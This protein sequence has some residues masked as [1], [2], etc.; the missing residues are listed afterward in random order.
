[1]K[2]IAK[3][4]SGLLSASLAF[5]F[6]APA[7]SEAM[8]AADD[9]IASMSEV[10]RAG[11]ENFDTSID[12]SKF[13]LD[14]YTEDL[15]RIPEV[16]NYVLKMPDLFY[17]DINL[18]EVSVGCQYAEDGSIIVGNVNITYN[19]T[20]EEVA[21]LIDELDAKVKEVVNEVVTD[22][23]TELQKA[24]SLHDYIVLNT[25]YDTSG[26]L[27]DLNNGASAYDI[28]IC[29]NGVCEGY[30]Q[31]YN[32]L[33]EECGVSSIMVTSYDMRH[34][35]NL[36]N[37][38]NEWYHVD[39]TWDD[40][41]PDSKGRVNHKYFMLSDEEIMKESD[42]RKPHYNWDSKGFE[43]TSK[44]YD[45]AF[46]SGV[47]TEIFLRGDKWYF[48]SNDG[49]YS[50]YTESADEV[51]T[52]V[53]LGE[54]KWPVWGDNNQAYW[55][56]RYSSMII[57]DNKVYFN[58]PEM[59]YVMNLD[60]S[61]KA[62]LQYVNPYDTNG[63]VYGMVL[64]DNILYAVIKQD[65]QDEGT[66][67]KAV[68]LAER[69][70]ELNE[71][72]Y[73]IPSLVDQ[74]KSLPDG[75]S[76]KFDMKD[77]DTENVLPAAAIESMKDKDIKITLNLEGYS[78]DIRSKNIK[79][80][81]ARD[82]N[83]EIKQDQK[84]I[85]DDM[86][87]SVS[88]H[89]KFVEL[90]LSHNGQF[91]LTANISYSIGSE[92]ANEPAI[93]YYYNQAESKMDQIDFMLVDPDGNLNIDLYHASSYA[94]VL[95]NV[96]APADPIISEQEKPPEITEETVVEE[97]VVTTPPTIEA[98]QEITAPAETTEATIDSTV[99]VEPEVLK[100]DIN[101]DGI[102]DISDLTLL[103]LACIKDV[104][105]TDIQIA[106]ADVNNDGS[107]SLPDLACMK[108]FLMNVIEHF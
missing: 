3:F 100:G 23:M 46:W 6:A 101:M 88:E 1:M 105:L 76:K 73:V 41:I 59:I 28:L 61:E 94:V 86:V 74:I 18:Q 93:L 13:E 22:D 95:P 36:V 67:Y 55:G 30:A 31:A 68:D 24:L 102:V 104:T 99:T 27:P 32:M 47:G 96:Q 89:S 4:I 49:V 56:N 69:N 33:L 15:N 34:A 91:G 44:K 106:A 62:G 57:S 12:I 29:G 77:F 38:D 97:P 42:I 83:L 79:A 65:P 63:Y 14:P 8:A 90:N 75:S 103:S 10:V 11:F 60:G 35:W 81:E 5:N 80:E 2:K 50:T 64:K 78:W 19:N 51:T 9:T 21:P 82:L 58:T 108:Q 72:A 40:P 48:L 53:S 92:Y 85:P 7:V 37:I 98:P 26:E 16:I 54:E 45:N 70:I 25:V 84:I 107:V 87:Q 71:N 17:V 43:A 39:A 52:Y 20:P 66:L